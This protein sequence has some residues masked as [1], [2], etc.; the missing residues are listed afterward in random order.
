LRQSILVISDD[1]LLSKIARPIF[2]DS[3]FIVKAFEQSAEG[4]AACLA[5][6]PDLLII[7]YS[8]TGTPPNAFTVVKALRQDRRTEKLP[9]LM[10]SA[11]EQEA[12]AVG[13]T[14]W[15]DVVFDISKLV[16]R[17]VNLL[18]A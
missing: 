12:R 5:D 9:I 17:A 14:D 16:R 3:G 1:I 6:P 7:N 10:V 11:V 18:Q 8:S 15:V 2:E 4:V 13:V